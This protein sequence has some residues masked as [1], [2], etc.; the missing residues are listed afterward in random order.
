MKGWQ[1]NVRPKEHKWAVRQGVGGEQASTR[2]ARQSLT[3]SCRAQR[4]ERKE[5]TLTRGDPRVERRGEVSRGHS[6]VGGTH[7]RKG[8]PSEGP[9]ELREPIERLDTRTRQ[10]TKQWGATT[11]VTTPDWRTTSHTQKA[12][13]SSEG[14]EVSDLRRREGRTLEGPTAGCEQTARPVV[15]EGAGAQSPASDPIALSPTSLDRAIAGNP[16]PP[17]YAPS[18][19]CP[20]AAAV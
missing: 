13:N 14:S 15:W 11:T 16:P 8:V 1:A 20:P 6:S 12:R 5:Q 18:E 10:R 9:K 19:G 2:E 7:A 3:A 17:A 4:R